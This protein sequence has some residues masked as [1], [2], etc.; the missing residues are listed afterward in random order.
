[1]IASEM[2]P[3][4]HLESESSGGHCIAEIKENTSLVASLENL[5]LKSDQSPYFVDT[6]AKVASLVGRL[7]NLPTSP[8]SLYIDLEG[9][10]LS[11]YGSI[12]ILQIHIL[13]LEE[14]YLVDI[15][16]LQEKA[17]SKMAS[18]K[19][20]NLLDILESPL[21]P[22]VFFDVRNDSD[23]LFSHFNVK[24]AGV[25]DLQLMELATR[26]FSRR[27]VNG[28]A[29]CIERDARLT[30]YEARCWKASKEKG[31]ELFAPERGGSYEVFNARPLPDDIKE[32]CMQDVQFLPK[33]W[34]QYH[35]KISPSW[36]R[37]V[38][39]E[40]A[41]RVLLSQTATYDG[42]GKWKA[43]APVGWW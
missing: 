32:Y 3:A 5:N 12:S 35:R 33:L 19:G 29:K 21:I 25:I 37:K 13:P 24:L 6:E 28:L 26:S 41:N 43:L 39:A 17:F 1:M 2:P 23:A 20:H 36:A 11:R 22:K 15:H 18:D 10:D 40:S 38:T 34:V 9:V 8:P 7:Q 16:C 14:T 42:K 31:L 27:Y 4:M 30:T